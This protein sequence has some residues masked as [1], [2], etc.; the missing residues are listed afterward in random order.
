VTRLKTVY[1]GTAYGIYCYGTHHEWSR[2]GAHLY[3]ER[4]FAKGVC[5]CA[6]FVTMGWKLPMTTAQRLSI[7]YLPPGVTNENVRGTL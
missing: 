4:V 1:I 7:N 6:A 5:N 2:R 3:D